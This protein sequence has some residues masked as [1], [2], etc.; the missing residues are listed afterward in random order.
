MTTEEEVEAHLGAVF[1]ELVELIGETK[2]AVW[3]ATSSER[4]KVFDGLKNFV[5]EQIVMPTR[6]RATSSWGV[7]TS[8]CSHRPAS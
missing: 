5:G 8:D 1:D 2:Q 6:C 7:P 4:R 3:T